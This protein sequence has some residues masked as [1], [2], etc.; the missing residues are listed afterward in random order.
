M[1]SDTNSL[2]SMV[3]SACSEVQR[4]GLQAAMV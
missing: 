3:Q 4:M 1:N 2:V